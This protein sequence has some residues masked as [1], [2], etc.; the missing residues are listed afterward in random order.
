MSERNEFDERRRLEKNLRAS[1]QGLTPPAAFESLVRGAA[2]NM[3][4]RDE[5]IRSLEA[6]VADLRSD[7]T[8]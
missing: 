6:L 2:L 1:V 8:D 3:Y 4:L 7:N 5:R